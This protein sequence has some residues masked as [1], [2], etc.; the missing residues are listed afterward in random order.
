MPKFLLASALLAATSLVSAPVL[1]AE[2][3]YDLAAQKAKLATIPME[4]DTKFLSAE[5]RDVVN[6]LIKASDLMSE[7]Y[8]RQRYAEN[9]QVRRAVSMNRR[10]DRDLLVEMFDRNFGPWDELADLHPFWGTTPMPEGA[11]F[12]PEDLTRA[13]FE[14]YLAAH[15]GEKAA[16]TS[17]YTVVRRDGGKL[18]AV[19]YSVAYREWLE[20]AAKLLDQAAART[21]NASLK[22]FL[23]LRAKAFRTDDYYES[24]LA[25]MDLKDTPIEVAIGPYEVYTDRLMGAKTSFESFVTLKD[26]VESAALAKYKNHLRDMEANLPI[27]EEYKNFQR[28]FESPIAVAEQIR[29]GGDNVP[30]PQTVAFNLPNDERVREAK[31]AKKVILSNVL[32]AKFER[33]LKPMGALVLVPSQAAQVD[34]KYM[35]LETLFHELSHSLGPGTIVVNGQT[36][37][38]DK[39]LKEQNSAIEEAKA[40]VAGV[41]DILLMMQKG[42]IPAAERPQLFATYVAGIFRAVRFG[43]VEAHGKGAALQYG[44]LRAKGAFTYDAATRRY[45]YDDAKMEAGLRDLLHDM[46]MLQAK[47]DY[48]GTKAFMARWAKLDSEAESVIASMADLPVDIR[49]VYPE[50]I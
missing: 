46:L 42:E 48:A 4:V 45:T 30:G 1:A 3:A 18:V 38:V 41:W 21:S 23:G 20:P 34:R 25:W 10:A 12:Y 32:G 28:G 44:Y 16:L 35:Q 26:P 43:A 40:D 15:P 9:P 17:P 14:A 37:T 29:G 36:T 7:V 6:L 13:D 27:A 19:P 31:G 24:E 33:I 49:P 8:L 11:G 2:P 22:R 5:E 39:A 50:A 47:G